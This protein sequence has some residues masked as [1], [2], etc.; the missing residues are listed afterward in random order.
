MALINL[1]LLIIKLD[2]II[3]LH[4]IYFAQISKNRFFFKVK[5]KLFIAS[6][7]VKMETF[8]LLQNMEVLLKR[9]IQRISIY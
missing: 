5:I 6:D 7:G 3:N 4:L 2:D 1:I 9:T 8:Y